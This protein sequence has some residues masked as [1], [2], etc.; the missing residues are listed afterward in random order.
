MLLLYRIATAPCLRY[1]NP[2]LET[3]I[4]TDASLFGL[5]GWIGQKHDD[6]I[7]PIMFWSRKLI[8]AETK[9]HTHERELLAFVDITKK[10]RHYLLGHPAT[11][12]TDH[13]A[14]IYLQNQPRLS[15][16]QANWVEHF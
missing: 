5:G 9:Y 2:D 14:L 3:L 12:N 1:F 6:G 15:V 7:H 13:R 16:R 11:A 8:P 10:A 4:Y